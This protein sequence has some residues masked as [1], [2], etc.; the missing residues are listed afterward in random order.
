MIKKYVATPGWS[1]EIHAL[2]VER[3]TDS[4]VWINGRRAA[5]RSEY[6]NYFDKWE[7]AH[8]LLL[9]KA[10]SELDQSQKRLDRAQSNL[11]EIK[12]LK[13]F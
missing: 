1:V 12:K 9:A 11:E 2:E 8:A 6:H 4:S 13:P 5:K 7:G 10:Y 3:E